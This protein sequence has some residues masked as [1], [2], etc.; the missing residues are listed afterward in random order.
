MGTVVRWLNLELLRIRGLS[1]RLFHGLGLLALAIILILVFAVGIFVGYHYPY[2]TVPPPKVPPGQVVPNCGD[3]PAKDHAP[4]ACLPQPKV[5]NQASITATTQGPDLSNNDPVYAGQAQI[6]AHNSFE[7]F[8]VSEGT[9]YIDPTAKPMAVLAKARGLVVGGYDFLH[10]CGPSP[11]A[12]ADVFAYHLKADGLTGPGTLPGTGDA[13]YGGSGCNAR[14]WLYNWAWEVHRQTGRWPMFYTGAWWWDPHVG[15]WW[16]SPSLAWISGYVSWTHLIPPAGHR[17]VDLWQFS[18]HGWNGAS[19]GDL[20]IWRD[21]VSAFNAASSSKPAPPKITVPAYLVHQ[22]FALAYGAKASERN[23]AL[24]YKRAGCS[25]PAKRPT[26]KSSTYHLRLLIDR[27]QY[28]ATHHLVRGKW[29]ALKR[30]RYA[31]NH[32]GSRL[33]YMRH[34]L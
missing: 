6:A 24:T 12:E 25:Q 20:S 33:A 32:L 30:P 31:F 2:K 22:A 7:I 9:G 21:G 19:T 3:K 5:V 13:E 27:D 34:L 10:V 14:A 1:I 23:T 17:Q 4:G 29:V 16:P 8:K 15:A 26:C 28:V 11:V 18:D